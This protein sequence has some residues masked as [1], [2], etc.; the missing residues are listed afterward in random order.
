M[1]ASALGRPRRAL[2]RTTYGRIDEAVRVSNLVAIGLELLQN[3][4]GTKVGHGCQRG[5]ALVVDELQLKAVSVEPVAEVGYP[6]IGPTW[7][8][9]LG[10]GGKG[11]W[12]PAFVRRNGPLGDWGGANSVVGGGF[13]ARP[14]A[15][16]FRLIR[17]RFHLFLLHQSLSG[18]MP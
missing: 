14:V 7:L 16:P 6:A 11:C 10:H 4:H 3:F 8:W 13:L 9:H 17:I 1:M 18:R 5:N 15:A 2:Q 12:A